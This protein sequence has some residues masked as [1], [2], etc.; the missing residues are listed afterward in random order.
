MLSPI[1]CISQDLFLLWAPQAL[2]REGNFNDRF[3][4]FFLN[5]TVKLVKC[6]FSPH[7][8]LWAVGQILCFHIVTSA[9]SFH[10]RHWSFMMVLFPVVH[11]CSQKLCSI[12]CSRQPLQS[13]HKTW[14]LVHILAWGT[15]SEREHGKAKEHSR[16]MYQIK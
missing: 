14:K 12:Q 2:F 16:T 9:S 5:T 6:F 8:V 4:G 1:Y 15:L 10:G 11:D 13:W 3:L 7:V